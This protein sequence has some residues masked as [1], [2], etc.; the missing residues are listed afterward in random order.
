LLSESHRGSKL[1]V[2]ST[3]IALVSSAR[4]DQRCKSPCKKER[5]D[6]IYL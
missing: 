1:V 2:A 5:S 3:S 4:A 6:R